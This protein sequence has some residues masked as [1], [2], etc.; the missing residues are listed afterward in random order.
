ML[1]VIAYFQT[2]A[3]NYINLVL[4]HVTISILVLLIS[5]VIAIPLGI[6]CS[7][8]EILQNISEHLFS[9][10]R[11]IPSLAVLIICI[12]FIG[13][14]W[15]PAVI[16]LTLLA[17]P[18]ILL[19]TI[20]AF[21]TLPE[22]I[23]EAATAMGMGTTYKLFNVKLPLAFPLIYTGIRTATVEVIASATLAAYIGAGGLGSLIFTGLGLMRVDLLYIG[24]ISV[25]I[26]SLGTGFLMNVFYKYKTRY[27]QIK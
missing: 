13:T 8:S 23:L 25:A 26:L 3:A 18:P 22:P 16:A 11:I 6:I 21:R 19:N 14:G 5:M 1:G 10:L 7:R 9:F 15:K 17:I 12:P 24:G 2:D 4:E 20:Q 27:L